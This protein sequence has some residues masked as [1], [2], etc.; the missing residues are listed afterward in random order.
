M[1]YRWCLKAILIEVFILMCKPSMAIEPWVAR[2]HADLK[3]N[4]IPFDEQSVA[5]GKVVYT[6][7]CLPCHGPLGKG[8]GPSAK[9]LDRKP[10]NLSD[11]K[12]MGAQSDGALFWK[13]GQG[14]GPMPQWKDA[15]TEKDR[16]LVINYIRTLASKKK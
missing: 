4:P 14:R 2:A 5:L 12:K 6:Q 3:K 11:A 9:S 16:W 8:D 15:I 13:I 7:N 1:D 10:G